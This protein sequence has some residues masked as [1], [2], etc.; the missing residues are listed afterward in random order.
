MWAGRLAG[1]VDAGRSGGSRER[2]DVDECFGEVLLPGPAGGAV[3]R[4]PPGVG[5]QAAGQREQPAAQCACGA[6]RVVWESEYAGPAQQ[7]VGSFR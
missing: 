6:D 7:V 1:E 5:G 4:P 3:Q 2:S